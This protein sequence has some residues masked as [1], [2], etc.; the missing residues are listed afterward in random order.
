MDVVEVAPS[1]ESTAAT[2]LIGGR[3]AI[4]AMAFHA[5]AGR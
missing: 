5:G 1:L 3:V 4:E 2:A